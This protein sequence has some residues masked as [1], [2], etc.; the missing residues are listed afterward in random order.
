MVDHHNEDC[1]HRLRKVL[2]K[3]SAGATREICPACLLET[4]LGLLEDESMHEKLIVDEIVVCA[5]VLMRSKSG[6]YGLA[7]FVLAF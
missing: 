7:N 4:G 2:S 3:T 6:I 1:H 5:P